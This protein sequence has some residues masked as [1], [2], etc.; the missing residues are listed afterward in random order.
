MHPCN[1]RYALDGLSSGCRPTFARGQPPRVYTLDLSYNQFSGSIPPGLGNCSALRVLK[2]GHNN[3]SGPLPDEI[4]NATS[5]EYLSFPDN[6]LHGLLDGVHLMKLKNL[7]NLDLGGN[8]LYGKIPN[9]IGQLT[10]LEE[11]H[12]DSNNMIG[13]LPSALSNHD[14]SLLLVE[15]ETSGVL[16]EI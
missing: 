16:R 8:T 3:F 2:A 10:R 14:T 13:E 6:S 7:V 9:S 15:G 1:A 4:F 12:L 11:L 5:L